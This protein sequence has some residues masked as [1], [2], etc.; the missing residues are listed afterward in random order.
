MTA[1]IQMRRTQENS[2]DYNVFAAKGDEPIKGLALHF[3][4]LEA[5]DLLD[6][7]Y[8][9]VT[10]EEGGALELT[11]EK[12][13]SATVKVVNKPAVRHAYIEPTFLNGFESFDFEESSMDVDGI[14]VLG[15]SNVTASDEETYDESVSTSAQDAADA[16]F[17]DSDE[18]DESEADADDEEEVEISDEE[19]DIAN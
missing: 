5:G 2:G 8:I 16:L 13:T 17:G 15:I 4:I 14:P 6:A 12:T 11:P 3:D 19:L 7:D 10:V 9:E 18:S 1:T